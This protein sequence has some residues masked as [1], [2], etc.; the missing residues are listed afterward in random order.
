MPA[1]AY[2]RVKKKLMPPDVQRAVWL[3]R[4]PPPKA[5]IIEWADT[6]CSGLVIRITKSDAAWLIRRRDRTIRIG[7]CSE[8]SLPTARHVTFKA[9]EAS[10]RGRNLKTFVEVLASIKSDEEL[11]GG[12]QDAESWRLAD[13]IAD[14][15][16]DWGLR[17]LRGEKHPGW[18]WRSLTERFLQQKLPELKE[19]YREDYARYLRLPEFDRIN[20]IPLS[21]LKIADLGNVRD[22]LM[23]NYGPSTVSRAI[24][25]GREML[26]WAWE[27][28]SGTC[29]LAPEHDWWKAW[30]FKYKSGRR[31]RSPSIPELAR[32]LVIADEF[33]N[34]ADGE[35]ETYPGTVAALWATV[36]TGQRTGS[37]LLLRQDRLFEPAAKD[38][39]PGWKIANWTQAEM[40]GGRGGGRPHA[41]P[42]PPNLLAAV[43][44]LKKEDP[45][46][47]TWMFFAKTPNE[48]L[49][50]SALNLLMYRL[51][52]RVHDHTSKN[53]PDR[54]GKPGP[55]PAGKKKRVSLFEYYAIEPWTLHDVR[56]SLTDFLEE[57]D[58]GGAASAVLAHKMPN[59]KMR[60][61]ERMAPVTRI[62][63]NSEKQRI[64]LKA[65]G[66]KLWVEA[67]LAACDRER[68]TIK[69]SPRP[70]L[71]N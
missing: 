34:L 62:H 11:P 23:A 63:Y 67:I 8:I 53:K 28:N 37:L 2:Q 33:R 42:L 9:R 5:R 45:R 30:K 43:E 39:L 58:L 56:R 69:K 24:R 21:D 7:P 38:K 27:Y 50:Q 6:D 60:E 40:K 48:R 12:Y 25:Q 55:K 18:T 59:D 1:V 29:G 14:E 61:E 31:T 57:R 22:E 36:L 47:S 16:S 54:P 10:K 51:Q 52:G 70:G 19:S 41:L 4:N 17:H 66:M 46:K 64:R 32:T 71:P 68:K 44:R 15:T 20:E 49:T 13:E 3:S 35:H 65:K 26:Y